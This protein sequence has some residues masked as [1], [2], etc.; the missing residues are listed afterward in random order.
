MSLITIPSTF[1][2]G[3]PIIASQHNANFSTISTDYNGNIDNTNLSASA[4]IAYS[5]L[6][7]TGNI[8]N[9]DVNGSAA[10]AYSKLNLTGN[11][12]N[13]DIN[14]SAAI[15]DSKLAQ[16]TTASKVSGTAIT[17]LASLPGGAGVI[18]AANLPNFAYSLI[19]TTTVSS[20]SASSNIAI[21]AGNFYFIAFQIQAIGGSLDAAIRFNADSGSN[22]LQGAGALT[23]ITMKTGTITNKG[24]T[25]NLSAYPALTNTS[26]TMIV[27]GSC[28]QDSTGSGATFFGSY[29]GGATITSISFIGNVTFSGT[30]YLYKLDI[31]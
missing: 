13:A 31:V 22:Y 23:S 26:N 3:A 27:T 17:G 15:V 24:L 1:S 2:A 4:A 5:K 8:V 12:V 14:A 19:S 10:I 28:T 18:P 21:T 6:S 20:A 7:L 9:T 30:I 25:G 11:I 29:Q 16:I